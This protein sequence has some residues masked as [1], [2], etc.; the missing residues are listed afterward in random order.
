MWI[1]NASKANRGNLRKEARDILNMMCGHNDCKYACTL[2]NGMCDFYGMTG[3]L[4][5]CKP[6]ENCKEYVSVY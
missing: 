5:K 1:D 6:D 2:L 3:K 4:R